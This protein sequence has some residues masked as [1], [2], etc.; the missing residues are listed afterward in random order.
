MRNKR[1]TLEITYK[2]G[3]VEG[4]FEEPSIKRT[5]PIDWVKGKDPRYK[6]VKK[7]NNAKSKTETKDESFFDIFYPTEL[8]LNN[9]INDDGN[10][11]DEVYYL[12]DQ[13]NYHKF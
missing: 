7:R 2:L 3:D 4:E 10:A 6:V 12:H 13:L 8:A 1:I 11:D 5:T 9:D